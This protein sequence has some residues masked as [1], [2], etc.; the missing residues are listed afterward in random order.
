MNLESAVALELIL[1]FK[2]LEK[3]PKTDDGEKALVKALQ[4]AET[5]FLAER[6]VNSWIRNSKRCPMPCD[7]Y[8]SLDQSGKVVSTTQSY[9]KIPKGQEIPPPEYYCNQCE[10]SGWYIVKLPQELADFPGQHYTG[11]K[12]CP[13][14]ADRRGT[15]TRV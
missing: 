7:I 12:R 13:H 9:P 8:Q 10:D 11:A 1:R 5:K 6:F 3:Y 15:R 2:I 4:L 14:P